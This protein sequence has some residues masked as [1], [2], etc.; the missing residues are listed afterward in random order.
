MELKKAKGIAA[1]LL[2]YKM[3]TCKEVYQKLIQKGFSEDIAELTVDEFCAAGILD[4]AEYAK[5]YIHDAVCI[6]MKGLYRIKQELI[7]KGVAT[8]I[9]ERAV[10]ETEVDAS[11]QL[12]EYA[13]LKFGN[14]IFMDWKDIEKAK[15]HL[16]RRGF[17]ISDINKCFEKLGIKVTRGDMYE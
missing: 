11:L 13:E 12:Y 3:Y 4:D 15:A 7:K 17:G 1:K 16:I 8:S 2:S 6:N 14:K 9:I 5:M 10:A